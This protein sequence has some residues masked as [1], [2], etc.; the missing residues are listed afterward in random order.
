[1]AGG[2]FDSF[3]GTGLCE[4]RELLEWQDLLD[5]QEEELRNELR[6]SRAALRHPDWTEPKA[7]AA[8]SKLWLWALT[9]RGPP[10]QPD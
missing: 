5:W 1:M 6:S 7:F 10:E 3:I 4:W 9:A 2:E 8:V